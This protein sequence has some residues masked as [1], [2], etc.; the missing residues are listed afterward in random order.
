MGNISQ[1]QNSWSEYQ[2]EQQIRR[3]EHHLSRYYR[4][5]PSLLDLPSEQDLIFPPDE[6]PSDAA[7][8]SDKIDF[9]HL[10]RKEEDEEDF[11]FISPVL[12]N[13]E[14]LNQLDRLTV[15]W[16]ILAATKLRADLEL[17]GLGI[18]CAYGK[19]L[20]RAAYFIDIDPEENRPLKLCLGKRALSD[21]KNLVS[22]LVKIQ[23]LQPAV[24]VQIS[25]QI[26]ILSLIREQLFDLLQSTRE[27]Q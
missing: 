20:V 17:P 12:S 21:L 1:S 27:L 11:D 2:W 16:N 3:E 23:S 14:M 4:E 5:L 26:E 25:R 9:L 18:S 24:K 7:P 13:C 10:W 8:E 6:P 19:L 22:A 15:A